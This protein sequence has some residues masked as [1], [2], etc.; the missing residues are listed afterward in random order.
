MHFQLLKHSHESN[1]HMYSVVLLTNIQ[2]I[3]FDIKSIELCNDT[4]KEAQNTLKS[5]ETT[6]EDEIKK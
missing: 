5:Q 3:G 4:L 6:G 2:A 1:Q